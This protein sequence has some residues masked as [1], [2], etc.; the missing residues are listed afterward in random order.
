MLRTALASLLLVSSALAQETF[1]PKYE[2][3]DTWTEVTSAALSLRLKVTEVDKGTDGA[4]HE[5][6]AAVDRG[7]RRETRILEATK[8]TPTA[9]KTS[10]PLSRERQDGAEARP[11]ALEGRSVE[12]RGRDATPADAPDAVKAAAREPA[13]WRVLLPLAPKSPGDSW[14]V[15]AAALARVL[16][17]GAREEPADTSEIKVT[18]AGVAEKDGARIAT[19]SLAGSIAVDSRQD[20]RVQF[21]VKGALVWDL[22]AG[23]PVSLTIEGEAK[24][25]EGKVKDEK[26]EVVGRIAD[27]GSTFSLKVEY[28]IR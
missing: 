27:D 5:Q 10:W 2:E 8:D 4:T 18:L 14:S 15:P 23:H 6:A 11:T 19:L 16:V 28:S 25:L 17:R 7:E 3:G 20:F 22:S 24:T 9:F 13:A 1:A 12:I 26:G 21:D